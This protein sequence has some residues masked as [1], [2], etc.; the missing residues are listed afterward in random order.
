M[1]TTDRIDVSLSSTYGHLLLQGFYFGPLFLVPVEVLGNRVAGTTIG[2]SNLFANIGG[3]TCVYALGVVRDRSGSF[4]WGFQGI[5]AL[6]LV[7]V[8]LAIL[9]ARMRTRALGVAAGG[10]SSVEP[11]QEQLR[12]SG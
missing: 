1:R 11:R 5:V 10:L 3:F 2:F 9:L 12:H 6:C 4:A 7:G 8:V